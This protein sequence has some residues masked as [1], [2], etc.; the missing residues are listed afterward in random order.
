MPRKTIAAFADHGKAAATLEHG[1][2]EATEVMRDLQAVGIDLPRIA[3]R[4]LDQGIEKFVESLDDILQLIE[5]KARREAAPASPV[6]ASQ[7][8]HPTMER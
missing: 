6:R 4:L 7:R 8:N 2:D 3:Q 1:L 5:T